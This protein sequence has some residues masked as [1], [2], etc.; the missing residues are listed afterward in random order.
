MSTK[1]EGLYAA[2]A[3]VM[4]ALEAEGQRL[5]PVTTKGY[6]AVNGV[7]GS[8]DYVDGEWVADMTQWGDSK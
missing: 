8:V 2:L 6:M 1:V 3:A 4:N 7:N 5:V